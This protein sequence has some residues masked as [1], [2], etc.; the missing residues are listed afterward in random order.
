MIYIINNQTNWYKDKSKQLEKVSNEILNQTK[1][2]RYKLA[3]RRDKA[4]S[5]FKN[6]QDIAIQFCQVLNPEFTKSKEI[7]LAE[8]IFSDAK[9]LCDLD[10]EF[11]RKQVYPDAG[12]Y[13]RFDTSIH[14]SDNPIPGKY[15]LTKDE[16]IFTQKVNNKNT[17]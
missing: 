16:F 2:G 11:K 17:K 6:I 3:L 1:E 15:H 13:S 12:F 4:L 10:L 5:I 8:K 14:V 7:I 9:K